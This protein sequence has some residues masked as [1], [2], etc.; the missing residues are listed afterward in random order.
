MGFGNRTQY[1]VV[2]TIFLSNLLEWLSDTK[3][4]VLGVSNN[5]DA[6]TILPIE[7]LGYRACRKWVELSDAMT[8]AL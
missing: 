2:P 1:A 5:C 4:K 6:E 7:W 3:C 8:C